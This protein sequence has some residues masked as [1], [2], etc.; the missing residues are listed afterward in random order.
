MMGEFVETKDCVEFL[1]G[2]ADASVDL[3]L[4]D[5]PYYGIVDESW[6]N[7][8][9]TETAYVNWLV[10][11]V[12]VAARKLK[13]SGSLLMFGGIGKHGSHPFFRVLSGIEVGGS[14]FFRNMITWKKRRAYGKSHDYLFCREEIVWYSKSQ[15]RTEVTFNIPYTD[16]KRGYDGFNKKYPAKS[17]YKRVS[18]VWDD[19]PE[20]M[21]PKRN[22]QKPDPLIKRLIDT[23][24]NPGDFVVDFFAGYGT[25][26]TVALESGR[27][28]LGCEAIA[29]DAAA[30]DERC[31]E[32]KQ[33][34]ETTQS[35]QSSPAVPASSEVT[36]P[37]D[38]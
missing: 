22:C 20:L 27:R 17:E 33:R 16:V 31:R 14:L 37:T 29:A 25:T 11:T 2:L 19:I 12:G 5:P 15:E 1:H 3:V 13:P 9:E 36:S 28:F 21:R 8:W 32:A 34:W 6:D 18:N 26:G 7:Q 10:S 24:S 30:A 38:S 4:I 23:H 35:V